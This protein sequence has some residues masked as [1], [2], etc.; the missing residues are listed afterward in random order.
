MRRH[1]P[2]ILV[3][4]VIIVSCG[5]RAGPTRSELAPPFESEMSVGQTQAILPRDHIWVVEK[6]YLQQSGDGRDVHTLV[7]R[8]SGFESFGQRGDLLLRFYDDN[9]IWTEFHPVDPGRYL[10]S[11]R[12]YYGGIDLPEGAVG[13]LVGDTRIWSWRDEQGRSYVG[14]RNDALMDRFIP[15]RG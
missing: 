2:A 14:W 9:L 4:L 7:A 11:L 6:E 13:S 8:V 15:Y 5:D 3:S 12:E 1:L 10:S